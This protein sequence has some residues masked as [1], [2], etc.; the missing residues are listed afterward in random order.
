MK[1]GNNLQASVSDGQREFL[2]NGRQTLLNLHVRLSRKLVH[3]PRLRGR[4]RLPAPRVPE[5][6][7]KIMR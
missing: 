7:R 4:V 2:G 6:V 1:D 3:I 5:S